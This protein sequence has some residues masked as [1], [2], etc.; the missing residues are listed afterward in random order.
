[1]FGCMRKGER[2]T[3]YIGMPVRGIS[4]ITRAGGV[5]IFPA[6]EEEVDVT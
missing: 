1:M 6:G 3:S 2:R 5:E 4:A